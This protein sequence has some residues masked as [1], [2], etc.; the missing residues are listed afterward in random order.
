MRVRVQENLW[1]NLTWWDQLARG[2]DRVIVRN[3]KEGDKVT[4]ELNL[5]V[6]QNDEILSG[7]LDTLHMAAINGDDFFD[8]Y[9]WI[10][11][12]KKRKRTKKQE[13]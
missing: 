9:E 5:G 2:K 1:T 4:A 13:N 6:T 7:L 11:R 8:V 12:N 10:T 3:V